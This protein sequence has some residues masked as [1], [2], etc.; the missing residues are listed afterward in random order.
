MD[1][2]F[3]VSGDAGCGNL[4]IYFALVVLVVAAVVR[5]FWVKEK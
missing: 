3:C 2:L 1:L 5:M 4:S